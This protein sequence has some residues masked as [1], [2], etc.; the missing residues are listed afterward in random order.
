MNLNDSAVAIDVR[1]KQAKA[2]ATDKNP[3][4]VDIL[5]TGLDSR[6]EP[7][8]AAIIASLKA[9]KGDVVLLQRAA[10]TKRPAADRAAAL[11]GIRV[12]KPA[13]GGPKLGLLLV[14]K[15]EQVREAA[16]H[17][18][19][20]VGTA[21]AEAN[22]VAALKAESS[23]KVRYFLATA[24]GELKTPAAKQAVTTQLKTEAD[25]ATKDALEQ[26]QAKQNRPL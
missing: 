18:L 17:A 13:D 24:L 14:D 10:D 3:K 1:V 2:L 15:E 20:V 9:Q 7:L 16:A 11:A 26:S 25:F 5:L 22:L 19:C 21:A 8:R 12:I 4:A 6:S 23:A